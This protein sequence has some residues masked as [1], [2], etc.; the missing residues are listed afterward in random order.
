MVATCLVHLDEHEP[1]KDERSKF[2][3]IVL[4][5]KEGGEGCDGHGLVHAIRSSGSAM[6]PIQS[7]S[8]H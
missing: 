1:Y 2:Q 3:G 5:Y 8:I 6:S 4:I 7:L